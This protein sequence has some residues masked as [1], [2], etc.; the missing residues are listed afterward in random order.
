MRVR[1]TFGTLAVTLALALPA[2]APAQIPVTDVA[3]ILRQVINHVEVMVEWY[4][5]Y[6]YYMKQ[7]ETLQGHWDELFEGML[8][9]AT[10]LRTTF[11]D[12]LEDFMAEGGAL[13]GSLAA[14]LALMNDSL[15]V[16]P[17]D[18]W[19][20]GS[21]LAQSLAIA[22]NRIGKHQAASTNT[23]RSAQRNIETAHQL[24]DQARNAATVQRAGQITARINAELLAVQSEANRLMSVQMRIDAEADR[25]AQRASDGV[26]DAL[27]K[28]V[29]L[30]RY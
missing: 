7:Y 20:E 18:F 3:S 17:G 23:Y 22:L 30:P 15:R 25:E 16:L 4:R 24:R 12:E 6:E 1:K 14:D 2:T 9:P 26:L 8:G 19:P 10:P 29:V 5:Q 11:P 27:R 13:Q 21:A 28:P